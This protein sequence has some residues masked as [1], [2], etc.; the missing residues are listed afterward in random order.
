MSKHTQ[1]GT[2]FGFI[3]AAVGSAIGLGNIWRFP[4]QAYSSGGGAFLIP[5]FVALLTAGIPLLIFEFG[6]G[7]SLR[8]AAPKVFAKLPG[9]KGRFEWVGWWQVL[10]CLIIATYYTVVIGWIISYFFF[11]FGQSWGD[12]PKAFYFGDFLQLPDSGNPFDW[13]GINNQVLFSLVAVWAIMWGILYRGVKQG[14]ELVNRI[15]MPLLFVF[16]IIIAVRSLFLDGALQG[17]NYLFEPNFSKL[18]DPQIWV[19]AYGQIFFS[20]SVSFAIMITYASYLPK[21]ADV[22][23]NAFMTGLINSGFSLLAGIMIFAI[24]GHMAAVENKAVSDVV[25][26]GPGLIFVT[27][28]AALK[29]MPLPQVF[30]PLFFFSL[31][32]AGISSAV[33]LLQSIIGAMNEKFHT[34]RAF[35]VTSVSIIGFLMSLPFAMGSGL[36]LLDITDHFIMYVGVIISALLEI[37]L[38]AWIVKDSRGANKIFL[39]NEINQTSDFSVGLW[40]PLT[41][42]YL[43]VLLLGYMEIQSLSKL[44]SEGYGKYPT[45]AVNTFGWAVLGAILLAAFSIQKLKAGFVEEDN[46]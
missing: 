16:V 31:I 35:N 22:V 18:K 4:Y 11:S 19:A 39:H 45:L 41:L 10:M 13:N 26:G 32:I 14:V 33:S 12:N 37:I 9:L 8:G 24:L 42:K 25:A 17:V 3:M 29:H 7:H 21:K 40:W 34:S 46:S 44:L 1:W 28:P 27:I 15:F 43:T 6:L 2:R 36:L 23:N 30:G 38:I 5:Y 20:L